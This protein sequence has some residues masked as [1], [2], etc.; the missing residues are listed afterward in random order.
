MKSHE[1]LPPV[2][3]SPALQQ[4]SVVELPAMQQLSCMQLN[5]QP[6]SVKKWQKLHLSTPAD[7]ED[8]APHID[9]EVDVPLPSDDLNENEM[10]PS[11]AAR[12]LCCNPNH[13]TDDYCFCM[14]CNGEAHN[15]CTEQMNFQTP[16]L[17]KLVITHLDF[18]YGGK[19]RYKKTP[20]A[21]HQNVVICL[22]CKAR[23]IQK[24]IHPTK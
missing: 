23:M 18:S 16:A 5:T 12:Q 9:E 2:I 3:A 14:N 4:T 21:H 20:R 24:I 17:D 11:C 7:N 19:E 10:A 8:Y 6:P 13:D 1:S 22:L 15:I